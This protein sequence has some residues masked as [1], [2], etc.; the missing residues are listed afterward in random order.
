MRVIDVREVELVIEAIEMVEKARR[1]IA[2]RLRQPITVADE[3]GRVPKQLRI[4]RMIVEDGRALVDLR[5]HVLQERRGA[6]G[7]APIDGR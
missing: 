5:E 4:R 6:S 1:V 3:G 2:R 7:C